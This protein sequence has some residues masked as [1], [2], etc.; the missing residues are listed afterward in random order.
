M[1][2]TDLPFEVKDYIKDYRIEMQSDTYE[3]WVWELGLQYGC[4]FMNFNGYD[5]LL[6]LPEE[7]RS[8]ISL[9]WLVISPDNNLLMLYLEDTSFWVE[10][11]SQWCE[12]DVDKR[13]RTD[14]V[15]IA[16]KVP[17]QTFYIATF[18]HHGILNKQPGS[19]PWLPRHQ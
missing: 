4:M 9:I 8:N 1:Q 12:S 18:Y 10:E 2:P 6:P 7:Q 17:E 5:V 16:E 3:W 13:R 11:D 19:G 14:F 15:T